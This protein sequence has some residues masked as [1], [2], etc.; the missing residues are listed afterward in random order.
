MRHFL[1]TP[2]HHL[3]GEPLALM[4]QVQGLVHVLEYLDAIRGKV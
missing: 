2:N 3:A 1:R 4:G